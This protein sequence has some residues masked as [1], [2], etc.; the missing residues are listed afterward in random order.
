MKTRINVQKKLPCNINF[1]IKIRKNK[2]WNHDDY[3]NK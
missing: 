3:K 2:N 1:I